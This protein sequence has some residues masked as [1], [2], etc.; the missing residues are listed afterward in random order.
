MGPQ[1]FHTIG[2][3]VIV[4]EVKLLDGRQVCQVGAQRFRTTGADEIV[5]DVRLLERP[6]VC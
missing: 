1:E 2:V 3:N 5:A 4:A 6:K